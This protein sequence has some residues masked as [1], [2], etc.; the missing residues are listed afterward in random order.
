MEKYKNDLHLVVSAWVYYMANA[1]CKEEAV[2]IYGEVMGT[3][4]WDKWVGLNDGRKSADAA[5]MGL[6]FAMSG[7]YREQLV[8][9]AMEHYAES[10]WILNQ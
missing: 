2:A 10:G 9:R 8:Q 7:H 1:W 3:H 6:Y 4:F 5:S